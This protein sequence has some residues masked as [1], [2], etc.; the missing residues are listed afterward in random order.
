MVV[1]RR[2]IYIYTFKKSK[3]T[4]LELEYSKSLPVA[5]KMMRAT[6]ASQRMESSS[7]FLKSPLR[8]LEKVT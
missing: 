6:S 8:R 2:G 3:V 1:G 5:E 7:A 4:Y